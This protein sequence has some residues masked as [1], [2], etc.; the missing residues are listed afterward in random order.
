M[1]ETVQPLK[2]ATRPNPDHLPERYQSL[3]LWR[4]IKSGRWMLVPCT[5]WVG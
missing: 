4:D 3:G 1:R 5:C 2:G